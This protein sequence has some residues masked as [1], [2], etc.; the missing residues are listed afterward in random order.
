MSGSLVSA[1]PDGRERPLA[2][3]AQVVVPPHGVGVHM[4]QV[5]DVGHVDAAGVAAPGLQARA[6]IGVLPAGRRRCTHCSR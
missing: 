5:V 3:A 4:A 6:Q 2:H 1:V